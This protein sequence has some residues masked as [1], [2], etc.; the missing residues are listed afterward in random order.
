MQCTNNLLQLGIALGNYA[1]AHRVLPPGVV[2]DKGPIHNLP[3]GYHF[4]W[5]VQILPFIEKDTIYRRFD[6]REGV[7]APSN[8]TARDN[9]IQTLIC[10]SSRVSGIAYAGCH[11]D[12]EAPIAAD[13]KGLLYLNSRIAYDDITD[14]QACTILLG[15]ITAGGMTMGWASGTSST[16]RNTGHGI[17]QHEDYALPSAGGGT[18]PVIPDKPISTPWRSLWKLGSCRSIS[19]EA[20]RAITP[21]DPTSCL[22]M[23]RSVSSKS[24]YKQMSSVLL[25]IGPTAT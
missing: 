13:N 19:S 5:V 10:P 4:S 9:R 2:N 21:W 14:G 23:A 15:E 3:S 12:V 11:H 20:F 16:L 8:E 7:Y 17:N 24:Q 1:S 18:S 6:F 22:L 25:A